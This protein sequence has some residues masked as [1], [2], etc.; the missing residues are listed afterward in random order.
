MNFGQR[1]RDR[2]SKIH[3]VTPI[4]SLIGVSLSATGLGVSL[5]NMGNNKKL[6]RDSENRNHY[7]EKSL[8]A[9]EKIHKALQQ[10]PHNGI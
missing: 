8:K 3:N 10:N 5:T 1:L 4:H 7:D 6:V 2:I 9:L